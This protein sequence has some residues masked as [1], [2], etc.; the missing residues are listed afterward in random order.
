[1]GSP[2]KMSN[3]VNGREIPSRRM[4]VNDMSQLPYDYSST[5]GGTLFSTTP[6]GTRIIY[7]RAMLMHLRNSPMAKSPPKNLPSIPGVTAPQTGKENKPIVKS[8]TTTLTNIAEGKAM[9]TNTVSTAAS[10]ESGD[11]PQFHMDM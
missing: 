9:P 7:D 4:I 2:K 10:G 6:G 1:V 3:K 5:P 8:T 11:E